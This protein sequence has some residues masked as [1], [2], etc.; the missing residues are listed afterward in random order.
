MYETFSEFS[1]VMGKTSRPAHWWYSL[2][3]GDPVRELVVA[4]E[5]GECEISGMF[6]TDF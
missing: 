6:E 3:F 5:A 1:M 2:Y 4:F